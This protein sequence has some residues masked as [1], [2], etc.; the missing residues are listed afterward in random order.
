M[1]KFHLY[2]DLRLW[3]LKRAR[4][5][6]FHNLW[7]FLFSLLL[8]GKDRVARWSRTECSKLFPKMFQIQEKMFQ[9]LFVQEGVCYP[10]KS[11]LKCLVKGHLRVKHTLK[12]KSFWV[13]ENF[14]F[15]FE[16]IYLIK[17]CFSGI[18]RECSKCSKLL[19]LVPNTSKMFQI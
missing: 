9:I 13:G 14:S 4:A 15:L 7:F 17:I 5:I 1:T 10:P 6:F 19:N 11:L 18:L 2:Y 8:Y 3:Y 16:V 12:Y